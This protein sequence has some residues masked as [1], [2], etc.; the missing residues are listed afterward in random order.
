[1]KLSKSCS[2]GIAMARRG[3]PSASSKSRAEDERKAKDQE[4]CDKFKEFKA[5][6][7]AYRIGDLDTLLDA[8]GNP[9]VFPNCLHPSGRG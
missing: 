6:D 5:I 3:Y 8:L 7:D 9:T 2:I 4:R 1:M